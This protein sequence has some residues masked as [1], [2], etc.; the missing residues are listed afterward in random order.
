[1]IIIAFMFVCVRL[2]V[3]ICVCSCACDYLLSHELEKD[4]CDRVGELLSISLSNDDVDAIETTG[5][6]EAQTNTNV[7]HPQQQE[8]KK[9]Y[10][11]AKKFS[12]D[13]QKSSTLGPLVAAV[14]ALALAVT[15]GWATDLF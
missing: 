9:E 12:N 3:Y 5:E 4:A 1:M 6:Q 14:G 13:A 10:D 8:M 15:A 7:V 2:D 11:T